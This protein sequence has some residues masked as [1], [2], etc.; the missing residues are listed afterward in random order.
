M[1]VLVVLFAALFAVACAQESSGAG[2]RVAT[3]PEQPR[4]VITKGY[5]ATFSVRGKRVIYHT[6]RGSSFVRA[7]R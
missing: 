3:T 5:R 2:E 6:D 4:P 1:R 7:P